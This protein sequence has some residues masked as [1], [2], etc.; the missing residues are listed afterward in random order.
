LSLIGLSSQSAN[1]RVSV[2]ARKRGAD[3]LRPLSPEHPDERH[4]R[5]NVAPLYG[6][7]G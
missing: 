5:L 1:P 2:I 6:W 7:S 4:A 3:V